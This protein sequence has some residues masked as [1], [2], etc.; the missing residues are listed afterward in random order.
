MADAWS[1][2]AL[3]AALADPLASERWSVLTGE[4]VLAID[5][6][7]QGRPAPERWARLGELPAVTVGWAGDEV[8]EALRPLAAGVDVLIQDQVALAA[9]ETAVAAHP[10]ASLALVQLLRHSEG[11]GIHEGLIAESLVYGTLQGGPEFAAWLSAYPRREPPPEAGD[12]LRVEREQALLRLT[13]DRPQRRNAFSAGLRD[14]LCEALAL[15]QQDPSIE[16]VELRGSGPSFCSGGDLDEFGSVPD[17][18]TAHAV[19]STRNPGR[20]LAPFAGRVHAHIHGACVGAGIEI[21]AFCGRVSAR[22]DAFAM[23]PEVGMG[24]VPGAGGTVS[25]PRRI[26][27]QR[28]AWMALTGARIPAD[29]CLRWGLVDEIEPGG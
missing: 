3:A 29:Q 28:T 1:P 7:E 26:G 17:P 8:A 21:P 2:D 23:L 10:L 11:L 27:R 5:L 13:L 19:R 25:L 20:L 4:A 14:A 18:A 22:E 15:V 12:P 16:A 24:L 6:R 9:I